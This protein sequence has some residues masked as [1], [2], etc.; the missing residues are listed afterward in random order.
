[1]NF[2]E[3]K[4]I[5][6][7]NDDITTISQLI[8]KSHGIFIKE[9]Y[10]VLNAIIDG[11]FNIDESKKCLAKKLLAEFQQSRNDENYKE[12]LTYINYFPVPHILDSDWRF[13][14]ETTNYLCKTVKSYL[15]DKKSNLVMLGVP[16]LFLLINDDPQLLS[17][18]GMLLIERNS[19]S[20]N[21]LNNTGI[22]CGD[23]RQMNLYNYADV[24]LCDPPWYMGAIKSFIISAQEMLRVNA[25]LLLIVPPVGVRESIEL[26]YREIK[27]FANKFG[28]EYKSIE[29]ERMSYITPPFEYN[30][31]VTSGITSFPVDWRH[32]SLMIFNKIK[33][34]DGYDV[35]KEEVPNDWE[36]F[37]IKNI[38]F[39]VKNEETGKNENIAHLCPNDIY[40]S[41]SMRLEVKNQANVWTSGNRIYKCKNSR[42]F[43]T[44]LKEIDAFGFDN[45][46]DVVKNHN[47][48]EEREVS[49]Y[50]F[51]IKDIVDQE[52]KEYGSLWG[53]A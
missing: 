10:D 51:L 37:S 5:D 34:V 19:L 9:I 39:K 16:S 28:F 15:K 30:A 24:L 26:E 11:C 21:H 46:Q 20:Q 36:D 47:G 45:R 48:K 44:V 42:L 7:L 12:A 50:V 8:D 1:M 40:P 38:R 25:Q 33:E 4:V 43:A 29:T 32:G 27:D 6:I 3:S 52:M 53:R 2:F 41:V 23:I 31:L 17:K 14:R 13:T 18:C 35:E 22:V 49:D